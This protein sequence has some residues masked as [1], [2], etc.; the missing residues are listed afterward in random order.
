MCRKTAPVILNEVIKDCS[1]VSVWKSPSREVGQVSQR[2]N[3]AATISK[4][5]HAA[6]QGS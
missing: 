1:G 6:Y 4:L 2:P 5:P 3:L